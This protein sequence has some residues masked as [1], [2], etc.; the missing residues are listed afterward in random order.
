MN[1]LSPAQ[2]MVNAVGVLTELSALVY[3][4]LIKNG[5]PPEHACTMASDYMCTVLLGNG[6]NNNE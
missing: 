6:G 3:K 1:E 5:I 4:N 2:E